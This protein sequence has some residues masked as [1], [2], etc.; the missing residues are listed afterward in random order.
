M[1]AHSTCNHAQTPQAR[2]TCRELR[3]M[4]ALA[5]KVGL[6]PTDNSDQHC[7]QMIFTHPGNRWYDTRICWTRAWDTATYQFEIYWATGDR[8]K[9]R[10]RRDLECWLRAIA[11]S[12]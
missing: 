6:V 9:A 4:A 5:E 12:Q 7:A 2:R 1:S 11:P 3:H 8:K 10:G